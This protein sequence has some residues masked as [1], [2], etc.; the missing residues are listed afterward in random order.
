MAS[1]ILPNED[2]IEFRL[3]RQPN[4]HVLLT[5]TACEPPKGWDCSTEIMA[6]MRMRHHRAEHF[7]EKLGLDR[8]TRLG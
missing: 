2:E 7:D 5:C 6:L 8:K 1:P 4:G 3:V